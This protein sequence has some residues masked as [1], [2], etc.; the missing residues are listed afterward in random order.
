MPTELT[1]TVGQ[2]PDDTGYFAHASFVEGG[3]DYGV[4]T[5]GDTFEELRQ[6]VMEA[7]ALTCEEIGPPATIHLHF[8]E[9]FRAPAARLP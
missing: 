2:D 1:F 7:V 4:V 5:E 6:M 8:T 9:P 3:A